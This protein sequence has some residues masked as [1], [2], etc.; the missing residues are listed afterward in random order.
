L[1]GIVLDYELE[2]AGASRLRAKEKLT[3]PVY[4]TLSNGSEG[5]GRSCIW[6]PENSRIGGISRYFSPFQ[7]ITALSTSL[8]LIFMAPVCPSL[9]HVQDWY[10]VVPKRAL[11]QKDT[12][13]RLAPRRRSGPKSHGCSIGLSV[14]KNMF[15]VKKK[16]EWMRFKQ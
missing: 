13:F 3:E 5:H 16:V 9:R 11:V 1:N 15:L 6:F 4:Q 2:I 10:W 7:S 14:P 8:L 12:A